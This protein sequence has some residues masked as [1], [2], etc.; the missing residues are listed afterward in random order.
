MEQDLFEILEEIEEEEKKENR[1]ATGE[2]LI[3]L[4]NGR[5]VTASSADR[6]RLC[7]VLRHKIDPRTGMLTGY[8]QRCELYEYCDNCLK[9]R[10]GEEQTAFIGALENK[11]KV[12][13]V[14]V[15]GKNQDEIKDIPTNKCRKFPQDNETVIV[16]HTVDEVGGEEVDPYELDW[17]EMTNTPKGRNISGKLCLSLSNPKSMRFPMVLWLD[18]YRHPMRDLSK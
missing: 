1:K 12:Y 6:V 18:T 4:P 2:L 9:H 14:I 10:A 17:Q 13:R 16:L 15:N 11:R 8:Y 7:G 3:R 5:L